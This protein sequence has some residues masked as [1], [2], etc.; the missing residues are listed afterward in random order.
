MNEIEVEGKKRLDQEMCRINKLEQEECARIRKECA[1]RNEQEVREVEEEYKRKIDELNKEYQKK[2]NSELNLIKKD[3]KANDGE[4]ERKRSLLSKEIEKR[5]AE[6]S[7]DIEQYRQK[8]L[9]EMQEQIELDVKEYARKRMDANNEMNEQLK[10]KLDLENRN[11][12]Q[13]AKLEGTMR[14]NEI[15]ELYQ[16]RQTDETKAL[17]EK[18]NA[19]ISDLKIQDETNK[20]EKICA[21]RNQY[22]LEME[23]IKLETEKLYQEERKALEVKLSQAEAHLNERLRLENMELERRTKM[24]KDLLQVLSMK[25]IIKIAEE[26]FLL[27][28]NYKIQRNSVVTQGK[29][30]TI[31]DSIVNTDGKCYCKVTLFNKW[32]SRHKQE[33]FKMD[34]RIMHYVS[35]VPMNQQNQQYLTQFS[36]KLPFV[37]VLDMFATDKKFYTFME[38]LESHKRLDQVIQAMAIK[39][40]KKNKSSTSINSA[41]ISSFK[42]LSKTDVV[43]IMTQVAQGLRFLNDIF[44]AHMNVVAENVTLIENNNGE[45]RVVLT[46]MTRSIVYYNVERDEFC[47][48]KGFELVEPY[49]E[50]LAPECFQPEFL[51]KSVDIYSLGCLIYHAHV[52]AA[53]FEKH[54]SQKKMLSIKSAQS[55]SIPD[56]D[57]NDDM[58]QFVRY[59]TEPDQSKRLA[60]DVV[61]EQPFFKKFQYYKI[62]K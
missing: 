12:M 53:P 51:P 42:E 20:E 8:R 48:T 58:Q 57:S 26:E 60:L 59:S 5:N 55:I 37:K 1:E 15:K 6:V 29:L 11:D 36:N 3:E 21:L 49:S 30:S 61:L 56:L 19:K 13:R 38:P 35:Q 16:K 33:C 43:A 34:G 4:M 22:Q 39:A 24:K 40:N 41:D 54:G 52:K 28:Y 25:T 62:K 47:K 2:M 44:I 31:Y 46:G 50:H 32:S 18:M 10:V 9:K 17:Y 45:Y 23:K 27:K 14:I 7:A